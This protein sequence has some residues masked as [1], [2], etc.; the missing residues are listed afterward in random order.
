MLKNRMGPRRRIPMIFSERLGQFA[1]D[2]D[3]QLSK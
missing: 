1:E 3:R 2:P